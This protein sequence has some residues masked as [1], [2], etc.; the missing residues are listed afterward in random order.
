MLIIVFTS[1]STAV[2]LQSFSTEPNAC[3]VACLQQDS[4]AVQATA[5][6]KLYQ[7]PRYISN[8]KIDFLVYVFVKTFFE[9]GMT[10]VFAIE[11][12]LNSLMLEVEL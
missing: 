3:A 1:V 2:K 7:L 8:K 4:S 11:S 9:L 10:L 12:S 5:R 6:L